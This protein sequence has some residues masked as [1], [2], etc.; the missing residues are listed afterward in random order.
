VTAPGLFRGLLG[1]Q[2]DHLA[3]RVREVHAGRTLQLRGRATV[4]RGDALVGRIIGRLASLPDAQ[5]EAP[6]CIDLVVEGGGETWT[7]RF[8]VSRPM[9][10]HLHA[11][12]HLLIER[13]GPVQLGFRLRAGDSGILWQFESVSFLGIPAPRSWFARATARSYEH[14]GRYCFEVDV[15]LP[16]IGHLI[17]YRGSADVS[18]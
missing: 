1:P 6:T 14:Q 12:E 17:G 13:L 8:G 3:P 10:S 11:R 18:D 16:L 7:R 15:A 4:T 9:R 5:S 2:F